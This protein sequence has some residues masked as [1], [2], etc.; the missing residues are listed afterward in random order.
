MHFRIGWCSTALKNSLATSLLPK[1][2]RKLN[3]RI[4]CCFCSIINSGNLK[5]P[6]KEH[7]LQ[8]KKNLATNFLRRKLLIKSPCRRDHMSAENRT[9]KCSKQDNTLDTF[10]T[11]LSYREVVLTWMTSHNGHKASMRTPLVD[12]SPGRQRETAQIRW[13]HGWSSPHSLSFWHIFIYSS[14]YCQLASVTTR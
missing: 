6:S 7:N 12:S 2:L 14:T 11:L 8:L 4:R 3:G 10:E 9:D 1:F 13:T 5:H